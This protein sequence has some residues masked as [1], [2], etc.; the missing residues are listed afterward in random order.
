VVGKTQCKKR[1]RARCNNKDD[2]T[3]QCNAAIAAL[4]VARAHR[5]AG[6]KDSASQG[7]AYPHCMSKATYGLLRKFRQ[8]INRRASHYKALSERP[9]CLHAIGQ[10][11]QGRR[12]LHNWDD[13]TTKL[14]ALHQGSHKLNLQA[15]LCKKIVLT[16][17]NAT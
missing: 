1:P 9:R 7:C 8:N 3:G 2:H 11:V 14:G 15:R 6:A 16:G 4:P 12:E 5:V 10:S 13:S 17:Y